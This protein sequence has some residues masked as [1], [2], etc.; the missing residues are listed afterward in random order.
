MRLPNGLL[1]PV[2]F[3]LFHCHI[4]FNRIQADHLQLSAA[5]RAFDNVAFVSIFVYLNFSIAFG[6][7][8]S[9][10]LRNPPIDFAPRPLYCCRANQ[11]NYLN[12]NEMDLQELK[13][14]RSSTLTNSLFVHVTTSVFVA[15]NINA[16]LAVMNSFVSSVN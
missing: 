13:M 4:Q 3:F 6:T 8:P 16:I 11:Q 15:A 5:V 2:L 14:E 1:S 9:W 12:R 7:S 10:H